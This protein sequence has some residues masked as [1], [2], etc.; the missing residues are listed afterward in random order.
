MG[1]WPKAQLTLVLSSR[2]KVSPGAQPINLNY[3]T[4]IYLLLEHYVQELF[5]T[6]V[7]WS[8]G[9]PGPYTSMNRSLAQL[10]LIGLDRSRVIILSLA[11]YRMSLYYSI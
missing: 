1:S 4:Y 8:L 2:L 6:L 9:F 11:R 7:A 3:D 10:Y 5:E